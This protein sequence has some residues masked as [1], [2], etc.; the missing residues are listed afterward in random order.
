MLVPIFF[1]V[2]V[3]GNN[4]T[5]AFFL[6]A[7][8]AST[9]WLDGQIARRTGTVTELGRAIDP[10][11]DRL[12]IG[13]GVLGVYLEG[14]VPLWVVIVL[15]VRDLYLLGVFAF[16]VRHGGQVPKVVF[17]GK[18]TTALL[19]IGFADLIL[20][21]PIV[22]GLGIVATSA[23]PGLNSEPAALG[24]FFLYVGILTS[25]TTAGIYTIDGV[26][27]LRALRAAQA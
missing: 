20:N 11:V 27:Q 4:D 6:F 19:L 5:V 22:P 14:R 25:I 18:L 24:I 12:L 15:L 9:D 2:L 26:R 16:T 21:W 8:A 13:A 7:V 10:V 17:L 23:L 3:A 1:T